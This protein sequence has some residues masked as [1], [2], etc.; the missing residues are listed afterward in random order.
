MMSN[1][2]YYLEGRWPQADRMLEFTENVLQHFFKYKMF[3]PVEVH[4]KM[5]SHFSG[6]DVGYC[7][8]DRDSVEINLSRRIRDEEGNYHLRDLQG[9]YTTLAHELVHAKQFI[10]GEIN[11]NSMSYRASGDYSDTPYKSLPWEH[12]AYMLE[13]FLYKL[14]WT[15]HSKIDI[16][17]KVFL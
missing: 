6:Y 5:S 16:T 4:L 14:Y 10:R 2:D 8:G 17:R 1:F 12:E 7:S 11:N 13:D 9:L 3:R 15:N